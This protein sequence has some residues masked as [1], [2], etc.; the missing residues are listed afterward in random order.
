MG[1]RVM[2]SDEGGDMDTEYGTFHANES[3]GA[4]YNEDETLYAPMLLDGSFDVNDI[5]EV[6]VAYENA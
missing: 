6:T 4:W 5:S 2:A 3:R 1:R